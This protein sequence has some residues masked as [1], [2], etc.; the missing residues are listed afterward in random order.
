MDF[1]TIAS[2]IRRRSSFKPIENMKL[3][4]YRTFQSWYINRTASALSR[5]GGNLLLC[6]RPV[7]DISPQASITLKDDLIIGANLRRRSMAETYLKVKERGTLTVNGRFQVFFGASLEVFENAKL[8][9]ERGFINT[10]AAIA[11]AHSITLGE[12]VFIARNVYITDSDHHQLLD[13][14]A[15]ITNVPEAIKIGNRV[16]ICYGAVILKGVTIGDGA[17][18]AAGSVVTH[19]VPAGCLA[20]GVPAKILREG[21]IWK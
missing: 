14:Q 13:Q 9:L 10:G 5:Q 7:C 20:G 8:T 6:G 4:G 3:T 15:R 16:L 2:D 19:D 12:G 21:V 11:C 18:I 17:V 1:A